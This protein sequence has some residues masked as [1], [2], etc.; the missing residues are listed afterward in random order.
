MTSQ[1]IKILTC[2][3]HPSING[4]ITSVILQI[5]SYDWKKYNIEMDFIPT[6]YGGNAVKKIIGFM[7]AYCKLVFKFLTN[8]P[9]IVH[10][11]MSYKGS[12]YRANYIQRLCKRFGIKTIIH[13]HGSMF[14]KWYDSIDEYEQDKVR[15]LFETADTTIVLGDKWYEAVSYISPKANIVILNNAVHISD[16]NI[17]WNKDCFKVL[18]MGVLIERKG[19]NDLIETAKLLKDRN[20]IEG[21]KFV[22]AGSGTDENILKKKVSDYGLNSFVEFVGWVSGENKEK[23]YLDSQVFILPSY[24]EGLPVA[25]LEAMSYGMPII[26]TDVGDI[27]SAVTNE[28][29]G[30]IVEPG[31]VKE[32]A[33]HIY[34]LYSSKNDFI[35][36]ASKSKECARSKFSDDVFFDKLRVIYC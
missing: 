13:L 26:T 31:D 11:H 20:R 15:K 6:Y 19:V 10:I 21:I 30:Y 4:G 32:M 23:Y 14:K 34:E 3:N 33:N 12:F 25:I 2:G 28:E 16:K 22:I 24:N 17:S 29:N 36:M 18:F 27:S 9:N 5:L 8:K 35:K 1:N 7:L